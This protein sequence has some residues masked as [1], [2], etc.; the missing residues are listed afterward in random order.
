MI[1]V[2]I[3]VALV[4]FA[5]FGLGMCRLAARSDRKQAIAVAEWIATSHIAERKAVPTNR[6]CAR[7]PFESRSDAFRATG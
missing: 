3:P 5:L 6:L 4:A 1:F 7:L 2:L